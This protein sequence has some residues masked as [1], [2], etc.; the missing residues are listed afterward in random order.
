LGKV[1]TVFNVERIEEWR[2]QDVL[3]RDGNRIGKLEDLF[4]DT[5]DGTASLGCVKSGRIAKHF[6]LLPLA[7]ASVGRDHVRVPYTKE[8]VE[9]APSVGTN[10]RITRADELLVARH[11]GVTPPER[12][13]ADD[14][15]RYEPLGAVEERRAEAQASIDRAA[16]LEAEAERKQ[17]EAESQHSSATEAGQRADAAEDERRRL[18][19]EAA[20]LRSQ[21]GTEPRQ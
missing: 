20:A 8:Q 3:D 19:E 16:E 14:D 6:S 10:G 18:L 4:S 17:A 5:H 21:A 2:G 7:G 15:V 13:A 12:D 11:Y 9:S 1:L